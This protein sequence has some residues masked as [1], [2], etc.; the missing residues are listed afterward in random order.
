MFRILLAVFTLALAGCAT[1]PQTAKPAAA[2]PPVILISID[3]FRPDYL[4]RG[5]TPVLGGLAAGGVRGAMRPSFPSKTFPNHYTLVTGL[6]PDR[7]GIVENNIEDPA[8]PGVTFKMADRQAVRDRRWWD[9]GEPIWVTAERAGVAAAPMFWPGA[10]AEVRGVRPAHWLTY[11]EAMPMEE[12]VDWLL[13]R[14]DGGERRPGFL[15]L[16]FHHIDTAGHD[17][18]PDSPEVDAML[19]RVDSAIGRL[20][21]GLGARGLDANILIV[22]DHGMAPLS[23]ARR[24]FLDDLLPAGAYRY[25]GAGAILTLYPTPGREGEVAAALLRPHPHMQCWRKADIPARF[26]YG[27]NPRVAPFFCLPKTGWVVTTRGY[28]PRKPERGAHGYDPASPEMAA[29]FIASGPAFRKGAVLPAFDNV[30]VYP[31]LARLLGVKPAA[32]DGRSADT[33]AALAR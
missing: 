19:P 2:R 15:T 24:I 5:L 20:V 7:H 29:V 25:L 12:R 8:I 30:S 4:D 21:A 31:L 10:E 17:F 28:K 1:T 33:E 13:A 6:R 11:D 23:D 18:G 26:H 22:A 3:G 9:Q 16:Y 27:R 32:N 14:L